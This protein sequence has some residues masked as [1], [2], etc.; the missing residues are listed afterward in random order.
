MT[1]T[2]D[3]AD[4]GGGFIQAGTGAVQRTVESKLQDVV[5]VKDFGAVGNGVADDTAAIQA[6]INSIE[7]GAVRPS[8]GAVYFPPG[9]YFVTATINIRGDRVDLIGS[10]R[11]ST[12]IKRTDTGAYGP[13]FRFAASGTETSGVECFSNS[14]SSMKI[15]HTVPGTASEHIRCDAQQEFKLY[16]LEL[17]NPYVGA[18]IRAGQGT[19]TDVQVRYDPTLYTNVPIGYAGFWTQ[20]NGLGATD[21]SSGAG[22]YVFT[23]CKVYT[24]ENPHTYY[25]NEYSFLINSADGIWLN[26]CYAR[27]ANTDAF[28]IWPP[29]QYSRTTGVRTTNCW[30]D[31]PKEAAFRVKNPFQ[32]NVQE[33]TFINCY[34]YAGSNTALVTRHAFFIGNDT[35]LGA[36][37]E[38]RGT[39]FTDAECINT[40]EEGVIIAYDAEDTH[41]VN[42]RVFNASF[43]TSG[44]YYSARVFANVSRWSFVGGALDGNRNG[45]V[46]TAARA[47][48]VV[49]GTSSDYSVIGVSVRDCVSSLGVDDAG[50]GG[51]NRIILTPGRPAL[52]L[53]PPIYTS[54]ALPDPAEFGDGAVIYVTDLLILAY[55]SATNWRRCTDGTTI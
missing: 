26:S 25:P 16:D 4:L 31:W 19:I 33:N 20:R 50:V 48:R 37:Y 54:T 40:R 41:F 2:R 44:T 52:G 46:S 1:K 18:R 12:T 14:I 45:G 29:D 5:S 6:A 9:E 3:L 24:R 17:W 51:T 11:G 39:S 49:P 13:T 53:R 32:G 21:Y 34:C 30:A 8:D 7:P 28:S 22:Q 27:G 38:I 42:P 55:A 36:G 47:L 35:A 23:N 10:G 43:G 15:I